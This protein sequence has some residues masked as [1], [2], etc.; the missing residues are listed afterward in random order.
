VKEKV[1]LCVHFATGRTVVRFTPRL[2]YPWG[3]NCRY[4]TGGWVDPRAAGL[5]ALEKVY[6][7][8]VYPAPPTPFRS[9]ELPV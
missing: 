7:F 2:S 9:A 6:I 3:N 5:D 1:F 8:D 4:T